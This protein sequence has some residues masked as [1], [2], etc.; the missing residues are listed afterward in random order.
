[1]KIPLK[2]ALP[3]TKNNRAWD[4]DSMNPPPPELGGREEQL[5]NKGQGES[6]RNAFRGR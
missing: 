4:L 5:Q 6:E 2:D 1:M 3:P